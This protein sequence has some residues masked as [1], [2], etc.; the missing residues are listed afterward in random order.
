MTFF[1]R[2]VLELGSGLGLLGLVI[3]KWCNVSQF[4]FSDCHEHVLQKLCAN[5]ILNTVPK[6][7]SI[8]DEASS[9]ILD[10]LV[11]NNDGDQCIRSSD[12]SKEHVQ[13][14]S[15][16]VEKSKQHKEITQIKCAHLGCP[17]LKSLFNLTLEELS[18]MYWSDIKKTSNPKL[19]KTMCLNHNKKVWLSE[20]D[21]EDYSEDDLLSCFQDVDTIVAAGMLSLSNITCIIM[22]NIINN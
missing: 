22:N 4:I 6:C 18:Q 12:F 19:P 16:D 20:L 7:D 10:E 2:S 21:W 9:N 13:D 8:T 11:T 5:I 17:S 14:K 3:T 1:C 15:H